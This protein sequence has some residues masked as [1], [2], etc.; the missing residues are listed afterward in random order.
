MA[1]Q[2]VNLGS[3]KLGRRNGAIARPKFPTDDEQ[4]GKLL[5]GGRSG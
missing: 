4:W 5:F 2:T 1:A 3:K